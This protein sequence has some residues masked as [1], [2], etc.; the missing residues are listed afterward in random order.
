M[1]DPMNIEFT[2]Y[3]TSSKAFSYCH[4]KDSKCIMMQNKRFDTNLFASVPITI[5]GDGKALISIDTACV[6]VFQY[7]FIG[8]YWSG[9]KKS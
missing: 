6:D 5:F 2:T 1:R 9:A 4:A 8:L 7:Y 3:D